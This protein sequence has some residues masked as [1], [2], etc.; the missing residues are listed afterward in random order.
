[1]AGVAK[2]IIVL[3]VDVA[4][5]EQLDGIWNLACGCALLTLHHDQ[6][7]SIMRGFAIDGFPEFLCSRP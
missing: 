5:Y 7:D 4:A 1:V 2:D 3:A 6:G